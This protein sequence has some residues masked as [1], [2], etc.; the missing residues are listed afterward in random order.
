[1]NNDLYKVVLHTPVHRKS[2]KLLVEKQLTFEEYDAIYDLNWS[3]YRLTLVAV[4]DRDEVRVGVSICNTK[5]DNF[6][7]KVG[8]VNATFRALTGPVYISNHEKMPNKREVLN[9]LKKEHYNIAINIS[10][11]KKIV[12]G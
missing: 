11:Y 12:N 4:V 10:S 1:M 2:L 5:H 6:D 3:G 8:M 9:L 7:K